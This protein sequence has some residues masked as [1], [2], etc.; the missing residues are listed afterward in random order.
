MLLQSQ[1]DTFLHGFVS[2]VTGTGTCMFP[3]V[4]SANAV[5]LADCAS[6]FEQTNIL[7]TKRVVV[8]VAGRPQYQP[9]SNHVRVAAVYPSTVMLQE[10]QI[11]AAVTGGGSGR[12]S[13]SSRNRRPAKEQGGL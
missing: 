13:S 8:R 12:S 7:N 9:R 2:V 6:V 11:A 3:L 10:V 4:A 1:K 5:P